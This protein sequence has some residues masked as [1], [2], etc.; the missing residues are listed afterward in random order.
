MTHNLNLGSVI[1]PHAGYDGERHQLTPG[2]QAFSMIGL[3]VI[4]PDRLSRDIAFILPSRQKG[5][6]DKPFSVPAGA[7]ITKIGV[8]IPKDLNMA[9]AVYEIANTPGATPGVQVAYAPPVSQSIYDYVACWALS[10]AGDFGLKRVEA[11]GETSPGSS[12]QQITS[13]PSGSG[14][15]IAEASALS[16]P[17]VATGDPLTA[18][19]EPHLITPVAAAAPTT[20][21]TEK[22]SVVVLEVAGYFLDAETAYLEKALAGAEYLLG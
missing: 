6:K 2:K 9:N 3:A 22:K 5:R 4:D 10:D 18:D 11:Q 14:A 12:I 17:T 1:N 20:H 19:W 8:R 21:N 13:V 16:D 7:Y 15:L